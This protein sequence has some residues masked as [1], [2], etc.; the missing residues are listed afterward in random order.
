[1]VI[2]DSISAVEDLVTK[3]GVKVS[4]TAY[5]RSSLEQSIV[6]MGN[7]QF[8]IL[9]VH[10]EI[11]AAFLSNILAAVR[12]RL[13]EF[14]LEIENRFGQESQIEDLRSKNTQ[15]TNIVNNTITNNGDGVLITTGSKNDVSAKINVTKGNHQH[16]AE[17]MNGKS[18]T[19]EDID[20]LLAVIDKQIPDDLDKYSDEVNAWIKKMLGKSLD[21]SWDVQFGNA[22]GLLSTI[23]AKYYGL[24][25]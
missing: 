17:E 20:E 10:L 16:L 13:L 4:L 1:M 6:N 18:I 3:K 12:S 5:K 21:G 22:G 23:L 11:P 2:L 15:V 25:F 7:P 9:D 8:Q 19:K 14:M 24:P